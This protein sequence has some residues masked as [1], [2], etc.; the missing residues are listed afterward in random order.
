MLTK[1]LSIL[2]RIF[3]IV[4]FAGYYF[5]GLKLM[6]LNIAIFFVLYF[7]MMIVIEIRNRR[8]GY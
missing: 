3:L 2:D 4:I 7:V 6:A 5:G 8:R 1:Y